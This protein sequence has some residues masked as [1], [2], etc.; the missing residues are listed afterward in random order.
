MLFFFL[1][2]SLA[3]GLIAVPRMNLVV[4]L[5]CRHVLEESGDQATQPVTIGGYNPQCQDDE[6][7][8][9][10]ALV[11]ARGN[12]IVGVL[13]A[14][15]S[16]SMGRLSDRIGRVKVI[17][18]NTL[19]LVLTEA[20]LVIIAKFP[21]SLDYRWLYTAY[22][23]DGISGSYALTMAMASAY[24]SDCCDP[25]TRSIQIGRLHGAM[26]I[27]IAVGPLISTLVSKIGGTKIPLLV[28]YVSLSM[29][30]FSILYLQFV[31]ESHV[32]KTNQRVAEARPKHFLRATARAC[33]PQLN[34]S[35][36]DPRA[37]IAHLIPP[38][39]LDS[40]H[41]RRNL[42]LL[43]LIDL[44]IYAG[45][46]GTME[47]LIL[48]PQVVFSWGSTAN[49]LFMSI[50]N[51]FRAAVS[52]L[53][54]PLLIALFRRSSPRLAK[55][56]STTKPTDPDSGSSQTGADA[57]DKALIRASIL[58]DIAGY[59]GFGFAPS[60]V[61]FTI[62]GALAAFAATGLASTEA[63]LTKHVDGERTGELMGGLGFLQGVVRVIAP[64]LVN[65]V[66]SW[67]VKEGVPQAAF[68]GIAGFLCLGAVLTFLVRTR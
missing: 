61:V 42:I 29:R 26:F 41:L 22:A 32:A 17:A 59:L 63:T 7:S 19:G 58:I 14:A 57:L 18:F 66:Y 9:Q 6:V 65:V 52:T 21:D 35:K 25:S 54:L 47:I 15:V 44:I 12:I 33:K 30:L 2:N 38:S 20:T 5:V 50:V 45:V 23:I 1:I 67:T 36:L 51:G 10:T 31:P 34:I 68:L 13:A 64:S 49:N 4:S 11:A 40:A 16:T 55:A 46:M 28:F 56:S 8:S 24:V 27:G 3:F 43:I 39:V 60:G 48:Y 62:C 53:G 37:W